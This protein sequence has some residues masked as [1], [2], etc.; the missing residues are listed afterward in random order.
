MED[1][2]KYGD[3]HG[4]LSKKDQLP[5]PSAYTVSSLCGF[6]SK[7][8]LFIPPPLPHTSFHLWREGNSGLRETG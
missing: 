5:P 2:E 8:S 6:P 7:A 1:K 4:L 3:N